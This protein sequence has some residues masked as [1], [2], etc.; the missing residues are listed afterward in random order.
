VR[1]VLADPLDATRRAAMQRNFRWERGLVDADARAERL[2]Q[3]GRLIL[4]SGPSPTR[5]DVAKALEAALFAAG[6]T[7]YY[8]GLSSFVHGIDSDVPHDRSPEAQAEH[9]RR[10]GEMAHLMVDAGIL[11]VVSADVIGRDEWAVLQA[12]L[13]TDPTSLVWVGE[14]GTPGSAL[15]VASDRSVADAVVLIGAW[16]RE[17]G[18]D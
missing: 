9:F 13:G 1:R 6:R 16:L 18:C 5:K 11:L 2:G 17:S 8:L 12:V 14:E 3:R 15:Q 4:V 7:T 10:L